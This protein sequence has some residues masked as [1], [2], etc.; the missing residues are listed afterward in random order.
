MQL[1]KLKGSDN[2]FK[3][4]SIALIESSPQRGDYKMPPI[5]ANRVCALSNK[6]IELLKCNLIPKTINFMH[7]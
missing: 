6:T 3:N 2:L 1:Y 4:L 7:I 5:H